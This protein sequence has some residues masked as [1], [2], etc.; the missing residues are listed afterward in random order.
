MHQTNIKQPVVAIVG[1]ANVGKSSLF[2]RIAG[3]RIAI[4]DEIRGVT[5][6]RIIHHIQWNDKICFNLVDTGGIEMMPDN[7]NEQALTRMVQNQVK[8]ALEDASLILFVTDVIA[9]ILPEDEMIAELLRKKNKPIIMAINKADNLKLEYDASIFSKFGWQIF[10]I[11]ALH[12]RGIDEM[13][14]HIIKL[15]PASSYPSVEEAR[16]ASIVI[17]GKPNA[18]KSSVLNAL[19]G[20]ERAIV[21]HTPGTTRDVIKEKLPAKTGNNEITFVLS[22][23]AGIRKKSKI[24]SG[25]EYFSLVRTEENIRTGDL[26][27]IVIDAL[28]GPTAQD[29]AIADLVCKYH[30]AVVILVNKSDLLASRSSKHL[31]ECMQSL[32][33][34]LPFLDYAPVVFISAKTGYGMSKVLKTFQTV[35]SENERKLST[36]LL[37]KTL[38]SAYERVQP[39]TVSGKN[40]KIYYATQTGT[41]PIRIRLFVNNPALLTKN[42]ETYLIKSIRKTF[43]LSGSP[44]VLEMQGKK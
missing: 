31:S 22:D 4:V 12:N 27:A 25:I 34:E 14:A 42:Y 19:L 44:I 7:E 21:A 11:S 33:I 30:K 20:K 10:P 23:T 2:N 40:F 35:L 9:G 3:K 1:R 36:A 41:S 28:T 38:Q 43:R 18:G 8:I 15:L 26:V 39:P 29:K 6:D 17:V 24:S 37:N 32:R 13:L 16:K 5:R